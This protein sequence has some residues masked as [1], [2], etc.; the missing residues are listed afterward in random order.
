MR[1]T[2]KELE[3]GWFCAATSQSWKCIS[4]GHIHAKERKICFSSACK[5]DSPWNTT[6]IWEKSTCFIILVCKNDSSWNTTQTCLQMQ[7]HGHTKC[8][9]RVV[10]Q[11]LF[12]CL[13]NIVIYS[14]GFK[15]HWSETE[16]IQ[17]PKPLTCSIFFYVSVRNGFPALVNVM[18]Q[19]QLIYSSKTVAVLWYSLNC[20]KIA[21]SADRNGWYLDMINLH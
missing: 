9:P 21:I 8:F 19:K 13:E 18:E 17:S 3:E 7:M 6:Q 2:G 16:L 4:V 20:K 11:R 14:I 10:F 12:F 1:T 15:L 5:N